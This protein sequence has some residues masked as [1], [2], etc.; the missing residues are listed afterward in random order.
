MLPLSP[1]TGTIDAVKAAADAAEG[2]KAGWLGPGAGAE[3]AAYWEHRTLQ[4]QKLTA[5]LVQLATATMA[6]MATVVPVTR[7]LWAEKAEAPLFT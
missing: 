6:R 4:E 3:E 7:Y 1:P 5:D 2:W